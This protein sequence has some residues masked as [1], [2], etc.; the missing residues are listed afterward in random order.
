[1]KTMHMEP[2]L[3]LDKGVFVVEFH[4]RW[5]GTC[6]AVTRHMSEL[7]DEMG[8]VGI[9]VDVEQLPIVARNFR[10]MGVPVIVLIQDGIELGR[11]AGS[12]TKQEIREWLL[13]FP[14]I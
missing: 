8:F 7:E 9:L 6:R 3:S 12:L 13:T 14:V 5:C 2:Y 1:M 10:T 11:I 4:A